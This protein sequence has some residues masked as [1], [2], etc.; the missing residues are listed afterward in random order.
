MTGPYTALLGLILTAGLATAAVAGSDMDQAL[1]NGA[2]KLTGDE[3]IERLADK[4]V[5]FENVTT[6]QTVLVYYDGGHNYLVKRP[7][8]DDVAEGFYAVSV[9]D[10]ICLGANAEGPM[11]L[12]CV[13][14][15]LID[16]VLHKF[17]LDGGLRG[18]IV[19]EVDGNVT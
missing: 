3:I 17:E 14:V 1:A 5:T 6:G 12:R 18:R 13:N 11:K 7:G 15:L 8:S 9:A 4:T 2:K 10:H 16:G 19:E